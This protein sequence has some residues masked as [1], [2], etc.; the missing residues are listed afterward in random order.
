M[1]KRQL[2]EVVVTAMGIRQEKRSLGVSTTEVKGP[3]IAQT[4]RD[5]FVNGLQGRV[6]G[7][8]VTGTSGMPGSSSSIVIRGINSISGNNQPLFVI[9]GLP[10]SNNTFGSTNAGPNLVADKNS[11]SSFNNRTI[12]FQNR[13]GDLNPDDIES[14]TILK[15]PEAAALYGVEAANGAIL[16]TTRKGR[17]G[18]GRVTYSAN[19]TLE[20]VGALPELQNVYS[21]GSNGIPGLVLGSFGPAYGERDTLYNNYQGFFQDGFAQRHNLGFE[22]G[23]DRYTFRL[24]GAYSTRRGVVPTTKYDRLNV[25]LNGTAK[26]TDRLS[27]TAT[28]QYINSTNVKVSRGQNSFLLGMLVWPLN[29]NMADYLNAD[30][31]RKTLTA[32]ASE[33][34]NPYF[35]VNKN[36]LQDKTNRM[37]S[38]ISLDYR[39]TDHLSL[40]G[41]IGLD[42]YASQYLI[43]YHPE[44]NL[45]LIH[46]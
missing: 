11:G 45:S 6:A 31:T 20:K 10:I 21:K 19:F 36:F 8:T 18:Q 1:Y 15:G 12:D 27:A 26:L 17:T 29:R 33:I 40:V 30:G 32:N 34:E 24:S 7:V 37:L 39:L 25:S 2:D 38:N 43:K 35:D 28:L 14:M 13:A 42:V 23:T 44:S 3:E 5:N 4:Q 9:D 16:I 46:I 22:G 41:Q